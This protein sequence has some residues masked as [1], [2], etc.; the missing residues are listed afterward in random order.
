MEKKSIKLLSGGISVATKNSKCISNI[1]VAI[2][3][4]YRKRL[5]HL[6]IF[7]N[8]LHTF[9]V[10][11]KINYGIYV[12]EQSGKDQFNRGMLFNIGFMEAIN[13]QFLNYPFLNYD[14][15]IFHDVDFIP[16]NNLNLYR[17]NQQYPLHLSSSPEQR[18]NW[19]LDL[20]WGG[21]YAV[22]KEQY[23]KLN[24]HSNL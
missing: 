9:L 12:V 24:G 10:K 5:D 3:I 7:L 4:P 22:T 11:Q 15:F 20:Y 23:L 18:K 8:N 16:A 14:C 6:K 17:C 2:I 1:N 13:D 19:K 21:V